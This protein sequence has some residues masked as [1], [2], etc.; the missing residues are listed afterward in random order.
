VP[1]IVQFRPI[2][3]CFAGHGVRVDLGSSR[4]D[5]SGCRR[6][7]ITQQQGD[8][9]TPEGRYVLDW[10]NPNSIAFRSTHNL[11]SEPV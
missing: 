5:F 1:R 3:P 8:E 10:R 4:L 9:R 6:R 2:L 11:P 7:K